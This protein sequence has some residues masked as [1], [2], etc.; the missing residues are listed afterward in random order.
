[1]ER[2]AGL[3]PATLRAPVTGL[4]LDRAAAMAG[5]AVLVGVAGWL[6]AESLQQDLAAFVTA[7]R[8][9]A[10]GLDP[11]RN[12]L[13]VPG[14]PWDGVSLYRHSRF[15]YPPIVAEA[16]RPLAALPYVWGKIIFTAL[17]VLG[18]GLGLRLVRP[19]S[20]AD[21]TA[22]SPGVVWLAVA[23]WPPVFT[24]LERGQ[25]D[26]LLLPLLAL[27]WRRRASPLVGGVALAVCALAKPFVLAVWPMLVMARQVRLVL[28]ATG[29]VVALLG[30]GALASGPA[31]SREYLMEVLPRAMLHGEGGPDGWLLPDE[32]LARA[33]DRL[34]D[35]TAQLDPGG[36]S[37]AQQIGDFR[38]NASVIRLLSGEGPPPPLAGAIVFGALAALLAGSAARK[39]QSPAWFWGAL[40]AGVAASPVAWAMSLPLGLPLLLDAPAA[41]QKRGG[42]SRY[43]LALGAFYAAGALGPW[44]PGAWCVAALCG[45][46]AGTLAPTPPVN[47]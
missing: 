37:F 36:P 20:G 8:A 32:A 35:G 40:L 42:R 29:T 17:S 13:P 21:D 44:L 34:A 11:Y 14:A 38:R 39:P 2:P 12:H 25:I 22:A 46:A 47:S 43:G 31:L 28:A 19:P 7:G 15:L 9:R 27:A 6:V 24:T 10:A 23:A 45:V 3:P 4:T 41:V 18:L 26:L 30:V 5:V 1:M 16:F 33:G